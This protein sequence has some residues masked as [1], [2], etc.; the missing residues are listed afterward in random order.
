MVHLLATDMAA[1]LQLSLILL[2]S[3]STGSP[4]TWLKVLPFQFGK[5][6]RVVKVR[7]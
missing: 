1:L 3:L 2:L 4:L 7:G 5:N 6:C